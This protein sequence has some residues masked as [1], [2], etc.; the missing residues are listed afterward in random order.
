[1]RARFMQRREGSSV[2]KQLPAQMQ[3]AAMAQL[4]QLQAA[5]DR[6][7]PGALNNLESFGNGATQLLAPVLAFVAGVATL[8]D[9]LRKV[10][11]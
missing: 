5:W 1:M 3:G 6:W 4:Q 8:L 11:G 10:F 2:V 9:D 7:S